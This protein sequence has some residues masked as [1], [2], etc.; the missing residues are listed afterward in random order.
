MKKLARVLFLLV[1]LPSPAHAEGAGVSLREAINLALERSHLVKAASHEKVA[2][3]HGLSMSRSRYFPSIQFEEA[4]S[5]SNSPPRVFMMKLDEGRF[6]QNDFLLS[7]LNNPG[8]HTDFRTAVS[9]EQPL[10]DIGIPSGVSFAEKEKNAREMALERQR[11][12]VAFMVYAAYLEVK[13]AKA[14]LSIADQAVEEAQEQLRLAKT[15][16][17]EGVGLKADELRARTYLSETEQRRITAANDVTMARIRLSLATG[18]EPDTGMDATDDVKAPQLTADTKVFRETAFTKRRDLRE[19]GARVEQADA[20]VS[21]ASSEF[22]PK[23]YAGAGYQMHDRD[24]PFGRENDAW[25]AGVSLR[26]EVFDGMRRW[27]DRQRASAVRS[28]MVER[29][30]QY[31]KEVSLQVTESL[32]RRDEAGKR[33]E[34]ARHAF[35]DAEEA[36]RLV[37]AR[38]KNSL[39]LMVEMLD[40]RTAL[41]NARAN[42]VQ[43][44]SDHAMAAAR[45]W[46]AAG[47]LLE[48]VLK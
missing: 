18:G 44:E 43:S 22:W 31:R 16:S 42:L 21:Q 30:E 37:A 36:M 10:F 15:R 23:L 3:D 17:V 9:V 7:N 35:L 11:E 5:A 8:T 1:A 39:A 45:V 29:M 33:L 12:D 14:F 48:E 20:G 27:E 47:I 6:T 2:A 46:H 28:A 41:K 19:L 26:W 25:H 34:V 40:A 24:T 4:F 38:F 32:L 13:K